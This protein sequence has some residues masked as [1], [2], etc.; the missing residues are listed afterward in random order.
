MNAIRS[1]ALTVVAVAAALFLLAQGPAATGGGA[2]PALNHVFIIIGENTEL[3]QINATNAPYIMSDIKPHSA[4]LTQYFALTHF[5][6]A[7]YVGMMAGQFNACQQMDGSA[8]SCHVPWENLFSQLDGVHV[9]WKSWMES[10]ISPCYLTST[11][12]PKTQD[13]Y[14]AKHNPAIFFDNIEGPGGVWSTTPSAECLANDVPAGTT[15]P[16][17]M[18]AFNASLSDPAKFNF[19]VPNECEDAHDNCAPQGNAV[20]QFDDFLSREV[21]LIMGSPVFDP[22]SVKF[23][24][25]AI[26]IITFD[27]GTSN[28]GDGHGHQFAGGGNVMFAAMG[29]GVVNGVKGDASYD[30]YG[31]LRTLEEGYGVSPLENAGSASAITSIWEP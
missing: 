28:R 15:A 29:P 18:S 7:N 27:E 22:H 12:S 26:L 2:V 24:P 13:H 6:E 10:M 5:S 23:D 11:G 3:G 1:R 20:T 25:N 4:W 17:D 9:S 31:L 16:K 8:A 21:P 14:G 30:H 19:V